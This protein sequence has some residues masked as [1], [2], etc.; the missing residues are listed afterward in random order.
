MSV[1]ARLS[2]RKAIAQT[3]PTRANSRRLKQQ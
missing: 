1:Q 2:N 3:A